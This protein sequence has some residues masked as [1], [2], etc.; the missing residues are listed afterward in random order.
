VHGIAVR[1]GQDWLARVL[2]IAT[3]F[4]SVGVV[5][6]ATALVP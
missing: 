6:L 1:R 3:L 2:G 4:G 5:V